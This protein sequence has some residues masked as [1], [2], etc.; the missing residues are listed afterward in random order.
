M[1]DAP[2]ASGT[3]PSS[4]AYT[5]LF[6]ADR[7]DDVRTP[8]RQPPPM[9][10]DPR[11]GRPTA[12]PETLRTARTAAPTDRTTRRGTPT[13]TDPDAR[14]GTTARTETPRPE[15]TTSTRGD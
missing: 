10:I 15:R 3:C 4:Y 12:D 5:D 1:I 11:H 6:S 7:S 14:T 2:Q 9:P 13:P 8:P